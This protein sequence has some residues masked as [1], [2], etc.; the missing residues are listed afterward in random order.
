[1]IRRAL[2][3]AR[4]RGETAIIPYVTVGYPDLETSMGHVEAIA[5]AGADVI[6]LGVPFSDPVADGPTIQHASQVAL[7]GG[8]TLRRIL[9]A[10]THLEIATPLVLM[11]YLNPLLAM[12]GLEALPLLARAGVRGLII[13]DLPLEEAAGWVARA[14]TEALSLIPLVAPTSGARRVRAIA[15]EARGFVYYVSVAGVTGARH[16]LPTGLADGIRGV[17][18]H[19]DLPVAVGFGISAPEHVRALRGV[20]GRRRGGQPPRRRDRQGRRPGPHRS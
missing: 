9:D 7:K 19:T 1:M 15:R 14:D 18:Q 12:G 16:G 2:E 4:N 8:V 6:E 13:P 3:S 11:T 5:A 20:A 17:R 10:T